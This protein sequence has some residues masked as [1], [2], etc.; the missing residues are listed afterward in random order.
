M[1]DAE[2]QAP[3]A[4]FALETT[5][6]LPRVWSN[7]GTTNSPQVQL[8]DTIIVPLIH[9]AIIPGKPSGTSK[10]ISLIHIFHLPGF[11]IFIY[12]FMYLLNIASPTWS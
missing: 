6:L 2:H 3:S 11:H 8:Q 10:I 5:P 12:L 7:D 1:P 9:G 4:S